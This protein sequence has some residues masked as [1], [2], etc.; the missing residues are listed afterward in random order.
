L[1]VDGS[2]DTREVICAA[3][4]MR[5]VQT[6]QATGAKQGVELARQHHPRVIVLD[7]EAEAADDEQICQQYESESRDH[8]S[9][10]VVLG[11]ARHYD[12]SLPRDRIVS[13]PYHFA[14]LIRT[15]ERLLSSPEVT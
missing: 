12:Q 11:R 14:P 7:L 6:L 10:L 4:Q 15:I 13:K 5:G 2:E 3:L 9:S 1:I 8:H